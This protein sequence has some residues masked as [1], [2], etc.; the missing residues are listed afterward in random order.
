[1]QAR[2]ARRLHTFYLVAIQHRTHAVAVARDHSRQ[3]GHKTG[4]DSQLGD[5]GRTKIHA[6]RKIE[7]EPR[8]EVAVFK[9]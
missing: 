2:A 5:I 9:K 7:Q 8:G 6:A 4:R 1:M 3:R